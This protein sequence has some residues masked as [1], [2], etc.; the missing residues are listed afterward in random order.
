MAYKRLY[1]SSLPLSKDSYARHDLKMEFLINIIIL[2]FIPVNA[3]TINSKVYLIIPTSESS[4]DQLLC[5]EHPYCTLDD[6]TRIPKIYHKNLIIKLQFL[7]GIHILS[8]DYSLGYPAYVEMSSYNS[9]KV[10]ISCKNYSR[11]NIYKTSHV[12][13]YGLNFQ[14]CGANRFTNV[15]NLQIY[16]STFVHSYG[17][18]VEVNRSNASIQSVSFHSNSALGC[19]YGDSQCCLVG[20]AMSIITSNASIYSSVFTN[21]VALSGGAIYRHGRS[22]TTI[23]NSTFIENKAFCNKTICDYGA[24]KITNY[25]KSWSEVKELQ[26]HGGA[27]NANGGYTFE[28]I[29]STF[30]GNQ[31]ST[32]GG[33]V[34][35]IWA[36]VVIEQCKFSNNSAVQWGGVLRALYNAVIVNNSEFYNNSAVNGGALDVWRNATLMVDST[37]FSNN[38]AETGAAFWANDNSLLKLFN[39]SVQAN[40]ATYGGV[41][42][43]FGSSALLSNSIFMDNIGS[44]YLFN[45]NVTIEGKNLYSNNTGLP[46]TATGFQG[47]AI[48]AFQSNIMIDGECSLTYNHAQSGGGIHTAESKIWI[49][50]KLDVVNNTVS[51]SGGGMH[52]YQSDLNCHYDCKIGLVNNVAVKNGGGIRAVSSS[53]KVH[54]GNIC[55]KNYTNCTLASI[56]FI[57]NY[58]SKGGAISLEVNAK[59]YIFKIKALVQ[60]TLSFISNSADK[61][62]AIYV[63]DDTNF[64]ICSS[65]SFNEN[66]ITTE[67]FLQSL[68]MHYRAGQ[69]LNLKMIQNTQFI[70]N[71]AKQSGHSLHGGLLDRCTVSFSAEVYKAYYYDSHNKISY[72]SSRTSI[73]G[74][75]NF[76]NITNATLD[77]ISSDPV[78]ICF[79][80]K[81][82]HD[83]E[84]K[85]P[86]FYVKRGGEFNVSLV[87]VDQVNH[88]LPNTTIHSSLAYTEGGLGEG[89]LMQQTKKKACTNLTFN[90]FSIRDHE[91]LLLYPDGPCKDANLSQSS[92][93]VRF[94]P[95][96]C[97]NG[98]QRDQKE[99]SRCKC[100]CDKDLLPYISNC[101][102]QT[103]VL[104]RESNIWISFVNTSVSGYLWKPYCP[105]DYCHPPNK[106]VIINLNIDNGSD[107]QCALERSG[108]LCGTCRN[109][110]SLSLGSSLCIACPS[111]WPAICIVLLVAALLGGI[112]LVVLILYLNLTVAVGSINGIIFYAN[113][114]GANMSTFF[115]FTMS[116]MKFL[117]IFVSWLNL[118]LGIDTCFFEGMD[119][120]WKMWLQLAFPTYVIVL[121]VAVIMISSRSVWFSQ[122][123]G[124][125]NPVATLATLILLSYTTF[126]KTIIETLSYSTL[127]YPDGSHQ[128]VWLPDATVSYLS[129]KH[130]VLFVVAILI[131]IAGAAY[132]SLL[133]SWQWLLRYNKIFINQNLYI[134]I[135]PYHAPYNNKHRYWTGLLLLVR[136]I[137]Y[138]I[139]AVNVSNN[140]DI[141]L[142]MIG[143]V[144]S[145]LFLLRGMLSFQ[146]YKKWLIEVLELTC[147]FNIILFC[148]AKLFIIIEATKRDQA[149]IAYVSGS[150][151]LALFVAVAGFHVLTEVCSI[152]RA[153]KH[154]YQRKQ[155]EGIDLGNFTSG[156]GSQESQCVPTMSVVDAPANQG[157]RDALDPFDQLTEP[158]LT[159]HN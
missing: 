28:I 32:S 56:K 88:T 33:A 127:K 91:K 103:Q 99:K 78:R 90:V 4:I 37:T 36:Q 109:G 50:G 152:Q 118:E 69:K 7:P 129:G 49:Y 67:C 3:A 39:I 83:C 76:F 44:L 95:C 108:L 94:L 157:D 100:E 61:G 136:A 58:A 106:R 154:F 23:V 46:H 52:L 19:K 96:V 131:L 113:I 54:Q 111:Y 145:I 143:I 12:R 25:T 60:P 6:F 68:A 77:S 75:S 31:A 105:M 147:Y 102:P 126:L 82:Y 51:E 72:P 137:L 9:S 15:K 155:E 24:C 64:G 150:I 81:Q 63:A 119:I 42:Y 45:S 20:G 55:K 80:K 125:K 115:P 66:Q 87:A 27:I 124:R 89:Q 151:T 112:A 79:C 132:T 133:I 59:L 130:A 47:G 153:F 117:S 30:T 97:P 74:A 142:L 70:G 86:T 134:F 40:N 13:I 159:A 1:L 62:G 84:Y 14:R 65:T 139:S 8:K 41:I 121:V 140:P 29:N 16:N 156:S 48:T 141:N 104:Y 148:L 135:E 146:V 98:F 10:Y 18:A 120:Y 116:N 22:N 73:S 43:L 122:I 107:S 93:D 110:L 26:M 128:T 92:V 2:I 11:F 57:R 101:D 114:V 123:I 35:V 17:S 5:T 38:K 85:P 71:S 21:N 144:M 53:I 138:V 149:I 34:Y 158:L